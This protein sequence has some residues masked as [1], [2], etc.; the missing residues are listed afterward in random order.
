MS[1]HFFAPLA[2]SAVI[3]CVFFALNHILAKILRRS[4]STRPPEVLLTKLVACRNALAVVAAAG[5][6]AVWVK[7]LASFVLSLAALAGALLIVSKELI[8]CW[9]GSLVRTLARPFSVGDVVE[10]GPWTGKVVDANM[11]TTTLLERGRAHQYTGNHIELPNSLLLN[12][13]VKNLSMTGDYFL[14][15]LTV[16]LPASVDVVAAIEEVQTHVLPLAARHQSQTAEHLR[17]FEAENVVSLPSSEAKVLLEPVDARTV[18]LVLRFGCPAQ[19]R[20][21]VEQELLRETFRRLHDKGLLR[22]GRTQD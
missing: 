19:R 2:S 1:P 8:M 5:L 14:N 9:L 15:Y 18:N 10:I 20:V 17:R 7:E 3:L 16:P 4:N 21:A 13:P 22:A 6:L 11:L 12:T